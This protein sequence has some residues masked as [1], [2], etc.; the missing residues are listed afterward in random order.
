MKIIVIGTRGIPHIQG[1]VETHCQELYPRMIKEEDPRH[2]ITIVRRKPYIRENNRTLLFEGI[3]LHDMYAPHRKS[4]EAIVHTFLSI[5]HAKKQRADIVHI[6]AIGPALLVPFAKMLGLKVVFTHHGPDYNRNKWGKLAKF[7]LKWG[8]KMGAKYADEVIV[9]STVINQ[10]L[11]EKYHRHNAHLV[12]N[13]VNHPLKSWDKSYIQS[14]GLS[15]KN[16]IL[17][18]GRFVKEKGFHDLIH[19]FS[20]SKLLDYKLVITGDADHE[21][22]YSQSL[23]KMA[24][25]HGV[26]LTGFVKGEKLNQLFTHARLFVLPSYH[27]GLP[28]TLLEAMSYDLNVLV[29]NIPANK[30]V[31][32]L[33]SDDFFAVG[34]TADLSKQ[35]KEK[36]K[37]HHTDRQYNLA[38]YNW[39][40]IATQVMEIYNSVLAGR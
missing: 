10:I 36:L 29:S 8:E 37:S 39:E 38:S 34:D 20:A 22:S 7:I 15:S 40:T 2:E 19:A 3:K 33:R 26:V 13:G 35:L 21:D 5:I 27:E 32:G 28:I 11:N 23:K 4:F 6:H 9:I 17:A 16:Y 12:Y 30:A 14:L 18:V 24:K 1:G 25:K 31:E